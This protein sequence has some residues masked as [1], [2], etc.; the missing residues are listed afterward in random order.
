VK[1]IT[2]KIL[3]ATIEDFVGLWEIHWE[4][5]SIFKEKE[6]EVKNKELARKVILSFLELGLVKIYF[7]K[8]GGND[9]KEINLRE[10]EEII[11]GEVFWNPPSTND[12][13]VKVGSTEKGEK[14]YNEHLLE[15]TD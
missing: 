9:L 11:N 10:A 6:D 12:V 8:W 13:C 3:W 2:Y 1:D 15:N 5:N 4:V 7:D 14:Y